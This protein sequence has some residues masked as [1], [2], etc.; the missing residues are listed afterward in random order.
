M[1]ALSV[2][3]AAA[4]CRGKED[5]DIRRSGCNP[6]IGKEQRMAAMLSVHA[7][8]YAHVDALPSGI[9]LASLGVV[10]LD[11]AQTTLLEDCDPVAPARRRRAAAKLAAYGKN[12]APFTSTWKALLGDPLL[13]DKFMG[14]ISVSLVP[15]ELESQLF[16]IAS[17]LMSP[18]ESVTNATFEGPDIHEGLVSWKVAYETTA[19][20][21]WLRGRL[22]PQNWDRCS[23]FFKD[24]RYTTEDGTPQLSCTAPGPSP[25][26]NNVKTPGDTY[27]ATLFEDFRC[28]ACETDAQTLLLINARSDVSC[29]TDNNPCDAQGWDATPAFQVCYQLV[30]DAAKKRLCEQQVRGNTPGCCGESL[31][32]CTGN[33]T[34]EHE[35]LTEDW[36]ELTVCNPRSPT[37]T[38]TAPSGVHRKVIARKN[39]KFASGWTNLKAYVLYYL[40]Q[41]ETTESTIDLACCQL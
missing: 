27:D 35:D 2:A 12:A 33:P 30:C 17:V 40:G 1:L 26:E 21:D 10:S 25:A 13:I 34:S 5:D 9:T 22:D 16:A 8:A 15:F 11:D 31:Y 4:G 41:K 19:T 20:L 32:F 23:P 29:A 38:T 6:S 37:T 18:C 7:H 28:P 14:T 3:I 24:T 36:G 39:I